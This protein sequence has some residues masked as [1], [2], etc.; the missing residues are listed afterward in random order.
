MILLLKNGVNQAVYYHDCDYYR[1][2]NSALSSEEIFKL[3]N[4]ADE[5]MIARLENYTPNDLME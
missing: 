4:I 5:R 3:S 1:S 2:E